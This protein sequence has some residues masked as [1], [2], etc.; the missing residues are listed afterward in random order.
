MGSGSRWA[1]NNVT[2]T[3]RFNPAFEARELGIVQQFFPTPQ[4]QLCLRFL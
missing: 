4:I 2:V 3:V 1:H